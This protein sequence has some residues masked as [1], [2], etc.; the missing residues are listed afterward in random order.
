MCY[1]SNVLVFY[2][3]NC[4]PWSALNVSPLSYVEMKHHEEHVTNKAFKPTIRTRELD[5]KVYVI[6]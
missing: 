1:A 4:I 2:Y 3:L 6:G 5:V